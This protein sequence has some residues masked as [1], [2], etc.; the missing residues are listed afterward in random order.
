MNA[1]EQNAFANCKTE[2]PETTKKQKEKRSF[3]IW[4][5]SFNQ[6][7]FHFWRR[8]KWNGWPDSVSTIWA[9]GLPVIQGAMTLVDDQGEPKASISKNQWLRWGGQ[10]IGAPILKYTTLQLFPFLALLADLP[11]MTVALTWA[12]RVVNKPPGFVRRPSAE[13]SEESPG[14]SFHSL[15]LPGS[16]HNIADLPFVLRRCHRRAG[17]K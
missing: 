13:N 7:H 16:M 2:K 12:D 14:A 10:V 17:L 9:S 1:W 5:L 11:Q 3:W 8:K 6:I 15:Q 4:K